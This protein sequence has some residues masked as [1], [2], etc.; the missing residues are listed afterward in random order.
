MVAGDITKAARSKMPQKPYY[1]VQYYLKEREAFIAINSYNMG[2]N[3]TRG[4]AQGS[5][6]GPILCNIEYDTVLNLKFTDH[7]RVV[8]FA[9]YLILM[10]RADSI[11]EAENIANIE[12]GKTAMWAKTT[13]QNLTK[14]SRK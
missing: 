11:S 5:C 14:K 7:T 9:D 6:C 3:I 4:C 13:K 2:K 8:A 1:L 12:M 10:M